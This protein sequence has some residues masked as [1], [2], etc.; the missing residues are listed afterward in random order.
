[1][2]VEGADAGLVTKAWVAKP[3]IATGRVPGAS[4][5]PSLNQLLKHHVKT[6]YKVFIAISPTCVRLC[7]CLSGAPR[8]NACL[9]QL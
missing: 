5:H 2:A 3:D 8:I 9:I 1:V 4:F 7:A 6:Y